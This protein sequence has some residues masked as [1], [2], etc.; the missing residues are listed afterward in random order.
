MRRFANEEVSIHRNFK[1][2]QTIQLGHQADR[3][4]DHSVADNADFA[5]AQNARRDEMQN[6]FLFADENSMPGVVSALSAHD[7]VRLLR[8]NVDYFAFAF[9]A[10]LGAN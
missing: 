7:D 2:E 1:L 10:P 4:D 5:F 8:Q 6:V 3:V 9:I